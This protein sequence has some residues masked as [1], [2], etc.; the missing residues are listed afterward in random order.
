MHSQRVPQEDRSLEVIPP[1]RP[2]IAWQVR[3]VAPLL[4]YRLTVEFM[5]G[6]KGI[7]DLRHLVTSSQAGIFAAL[8][9]RLIQHKATSST[10]QSLGRASW[11]LR[12]MRCTRPF[13]RTGN[14]NRPEDAAVARSFVRPACP[15]ER[16]CGGTENRCLT[17]PLYRL[18]RV[19]GF[20]PATPTSRILWPASFEVLRNQSD[21]ILTD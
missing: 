9:Q 8:R 3:A 19:T 18:V 5:D 1:V 21:F 6:L 10:A 17:K 16:T 13:A 11:I 2:S 4:D 20:E 12:P 15:T 7:V 14:G